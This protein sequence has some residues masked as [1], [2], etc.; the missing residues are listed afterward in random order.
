[1]ESRFLTIGELAKK[2]SV[3]RATVY[4]FIKKQN[5]PLGVKLG[6][7][8]RWKESDIDAWLAQHAITERPTLKEAQAQAQAEG[9]HNDN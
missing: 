3:T 1:M 5:F 4:S 6:Y 7:I 9:A 2:L 8:R